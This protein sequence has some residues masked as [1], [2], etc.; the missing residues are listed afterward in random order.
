M[1]EQAV[2]ELTPIV[3]TRPACRALGVAPATIYRRRN[4]PTP[5]PKR[6]KP[7]PARALSGEE[8]KAVLDE[9][10]SARFIAHPPA[11][12]WA[13]P[14]HEGP[15]SAS[16]RPPC[17]ILAADGEP[18]ASTGPTSGP[19]G[20]STASATA[21]P[22]AS[23]GSPSGAAFPSGWLAADLST[24]AN[25]AATIATTTFNATAKSVATNM[26]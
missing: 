21:P 5:Q 8:R 1:I 24:I 2:E 4:P 10:P 14:P 15:H 26:S 12:L 25:P 16:A 13:P 7:P 22:G 11:Q 18:G 17:R 23:T 9:L 19:S 6:S 20:P 3:G